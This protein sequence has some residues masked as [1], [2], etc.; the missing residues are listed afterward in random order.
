MQLS[1]KNLNKLAKINQRKSLGLK[2]FLLTIP[3]IIYVI[4][5][6]YIP[7]VGW[8]YSVFDYRM[9][10]HFL[11]FAHLKFIG[12]SNFVKLY[13]QRD[14]V[15][16]VLQNTMVMSFLNLIASPL[17]VIFAILLNEI[18]NSK[19]KK[20]VQTTTTLPNFISWIIVYGLA[21]SIFSMNGFVNMIFAKL[22]L[23][24]S[25][26]GIMG[27]E[28]YTWFFQLCLGIWKSMGWSAIIYIA[29]IAGVDTE[30][31]DAVKID[32]GN[33]F[34]EILHVTIPGIMPTFLVLFLLNISNLLNN[35]FDQYF[36]FFNSMVSN[37]IE[38]LDYYVYKVGM[39]VNDYSFSITL[40]MMKT[41]ISIALL[42]LA[43][44]ISKKVRG[45]SLL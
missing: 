29:A 14:E 43:N 8:I 5:F 45:D 40:G 3:F 24:V 4:A 20:L 12:L 41:L 36:M 10:Q 34:R 27:E 11:D 28:S 44:Y 1:I 9:G 35:G 17:P 42:F 30:L 23:P 26:V 13:Q 25:S 37:K 38:V 15:L 32:G 39:L 19:F 18:K 33:K 22:H 21:F 6:S 7:L 31:Y 16:R 2:Y